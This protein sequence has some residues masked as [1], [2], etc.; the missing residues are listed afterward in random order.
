VPE[1]DPPTEPFLPGGRLDETTLHGDDLLAQIAVVRKVATPEQIREC[2]ADQ[3][4]ARG[5]GEVLTLSEAMVRRGLVDGRTLEDLLREQWLVGEGV[6]AL[7]RYEVREKLGEGAVAVV[8]RAVDTQLKR[9]VAI[10]VLR[11]EVGENEVVRKRFHREAEAAGGLFHPNVVTVYDAGE[12]GGRMYI[13][14]ELVEGRPLSQ[15]LAQ[16]RPDLREMARLLEKAARGLGAAHAK[17]V[18]H[19]D[20]KPANII[21]G[22]TGEPKVGDFGLATRPEGDVALTKLGAMLGTPLY[23]APE[24]IRG[25]ST[26][27]TDVYALGAILYQMLAGRT[28]HVGEHVV[29]IYQKIVNEEPPPPRRVNP[30]A[31]EDLSLIAMKALSKDPPRRY[32]TGSDFAD[33]VAR[34]LRGEPVLAAE[35]SRRLWRAVRRRGPVA[36]IAAA[37]VAGAVAWAVV[38]AGRRSGEA[39]GAL[40]RAEEHE[41][42]GRLEEAREAYLA[43]SR[44]DG[45]SE[46]ARAGAARM[47]EAIR[48]RTEAAEAAR[49]AADARARA[50][51][52]AYKLLETARPALEAA[53]RMQRDGDALPADLFSQAEAAQRVIEEAVAKAPHVAVAH[54]LLGC[55]WEL[56][57]EEE[58]A[59]RALRKAIELDPGFAPA[60]YRLG[61]LLVYRAYLLT[62]AADRHEREA[63]RPL[64]ADLAR[65]AAEQLDAVA[66]EG[67]VHEV[68]RAA[69]AAMVAY[70]RGDPATAFRIVRDAYEAHGEVDGCEDLWWIGGMTQN[71]H[72]RRYGLETALKFRPKFPMALFARGDAR[73]K[74]GDLKGAL[75][76]FT[77]A[78]RLSPKFREAKLNRAAVMLTTGR[79]PDALAVLEELVREHPQWPPAWFIRGAARA[80][81]GNR[82]GAVADYAEGLRMEPSNVRARVSLATLHA[83]EGRPEDAAAEYTRCLEQDPEC[84]AAWSGRAE[85]RRQ[86]GEFEA[87]IADATK[88]IEFAPKEPSAWISRALSRLALDRR[89]EAIRDLD[90]A[91]EVAPASWPMLRRL[92]ELRESLK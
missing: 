36:G 39:A 75:E 18:V 43:A 88:A 19:R 11:K 64:A 68:R 41:R 70:T 87:A 1:T 83:E 31:P 12:A 51:D 49:R 34:A 91:L 52:D 45:S 71:G 67:T 10:K 8:Y 42:Q 21:V 48:R 9:D 57:G 30:S 69:A 56:R 14:M 40:A 20:V 17:G 13:V 3:D 77:E 5:R 16:S 78:L 58:H 66:Q 7:P 53:E 89:A 28:P 26:A 86:K 84:A 74:E 25:K 44:L 24:Q 33:D 27:R 59:E 81:G 15:L 82:A 63:R 92:K 23:M 62:L 61:R 2:Q 72:A 54:Y 90:H 47:N 6:P 22:P 32:A 60:R 46:G 79:Q 35:P 80:Q 85:T 76:D 55:A 4:A 65:Q 73:R 38:S 37:L 29:D 50:Q